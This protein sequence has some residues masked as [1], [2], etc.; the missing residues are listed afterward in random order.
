MHWQ[1]EGWNKCHRMHGQPPTPPPA[2]AE[3][4]WEAPGET[5]EWQSIKQAT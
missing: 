5:G 2:A 3:G 4:R 1:Y